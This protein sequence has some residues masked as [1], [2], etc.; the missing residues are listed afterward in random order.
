MNQNLPEIHCGVC[1]VTRG[2]SVTEL[3]VDS[4]RGLYC[5]ERL[6]VTELCS[7]KCGDIIFF[8]WDWRSALR[9]FKE[10]TCA[11]AVIKC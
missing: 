11:L 7:G 10:T 5:D 9:T 3:V 1:T 6:S 4:L 8:F 2:L